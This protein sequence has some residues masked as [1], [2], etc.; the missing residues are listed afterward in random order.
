MR[1]QKNNREASAGDQRKA[2]LPD[3]LEFLSE[4]IQEELMVLTDLSIALE[5]ERVRLDRIASDEKIPLDEVRVTYALLKVL[6][7]KFE[8]V[9]KRVDDVRGCFH[10]VLV[11]NDLNPII[12]KTWARSDS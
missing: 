11:E 5:D 9:S 3:T 4:E 1:T 2:H 10:E 12:A 8:R 7:D 6:C